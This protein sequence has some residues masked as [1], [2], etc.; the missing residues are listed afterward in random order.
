MNI[1][2]S[3]LDQTLIYSTRTVDKSMEGVTAIEKIGDRTISYT[4]ESTLLEIERLTK[5]S[6]FIPTTTRTL[7]QY[8]RLNFRNIN[9]KYVI[10]ANGG[11]ILKNG[12]VDLEWDSI[13]ASK[14]KKLSS[15]GYI[16]NKLKRLEKE[17]GF[18][19]FVNA[20]NFYI[21]MIVNEKKFNKDVLKGFDKFLSGWKIFDQGRKIY[22]IPDVISK[23]KALEYLKQKIKPDFVICSG[24]SILDESLISV[25]DL[26]IAPSHSETKCENKLT[27]IGILNGYGISKKARKILENKITAHK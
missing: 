19:K 13:I 27:E 15:H 21:Y 1:F 3:D 22:F 5:H 4:L 18:V 2:A 17:N 6:H 26:F 16:L 20:D 24:N 11:L 23:G 25:S 8:K 14:L 10:L 7:R 12:M 9:I